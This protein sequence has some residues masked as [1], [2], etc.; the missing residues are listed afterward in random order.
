MALPHRIIWY[1]HLRLLRR[2]FL[3]ANDFLRGNY[4]SYNFLHDPGQDGLGFPVRGIALKQ[5]PKYFIVLTL[6]FA[7]LLLPSIL[8]SLPN[9]FPFKLPTLQSPEQKQAT[10]QQNN[11]QSKEATV[12][13]I[14][15]NNLLISGLALI[16]VAGWTFLAVVLWR[17]GLVVSSYQMAWWFVLNNPFAW[18]ELSVYA[19][20]VLASLKILHLLRQHK[21]GD[22]FHPGGQY[23]IEFA[24]TVCYTLIVM[25]IVLLAS[26]F[27]E[28][29]LI[30]L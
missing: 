8:Q 25:T 2:K 4:P 29:W 26:A 11:A 21:V 12:A 18:I 24:K 9:P 22:W 3:G 20:A 7:V 1:T 17:T 10:V 5:L 30:H 27:T 28:H 19:Y 14:F 23:K 16:P 13:T 6:L 15:N